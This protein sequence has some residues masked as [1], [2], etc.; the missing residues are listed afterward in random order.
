MLR[1]MELQA[2]VHDLFGQPPIAGKVT[3]SSWRSENPAPLF[4]DLS[5]HSPA[6][7]DANYRLLQRFLNNKVQPREALRQLIDASADSS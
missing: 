2:F 5:D 3:L 6:S 4:S 7:P 1:R